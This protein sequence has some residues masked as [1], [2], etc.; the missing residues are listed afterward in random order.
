MYGLPETGLFNV[1]TM[2]LWLDGPRHAGLLRCVAELFFGE[3]TEESIVL[4]GGWLRR[5]RSVS[6]VAVLDEIVT[7]VAPRM[8]IEKT[9]AMVFRLETLHR[10]DEMYPNARYLH[11]LRH[12]RGHGRSVMNHVLELAADRNTAPPRWL[13]HVKPPDPDNSGALRRSRAIA[14]P[15]LRDPQWDWLKLHSN[16]LR[17]LQDVPPDRQIALRGE[18]LLADPDRALRVITTW[19]GLPTDDEAVD[20]MKHPERSPYSFIGPPN[21]RFGTSRHFLRAPQ[22]RPERATPQ[23]LDGPLEWRGD[24]TWF[25]PEVRRL[26]QT[27]GYT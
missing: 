22:L 18:D 21:A 16:I 15:P 5:R 6:T 12:P 14:E 4:A 26:A 24:G 9:P 27:L 3:Q 25:A 2:E 10:T 13:D 7:R 11:L 20:A 17:F 1:P 23:S 19:L 8:V